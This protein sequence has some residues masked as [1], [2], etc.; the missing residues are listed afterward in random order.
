L[1]WIN[2]SSGG[3]ASARRVTK[4]RKRFFLKKEAKT[5][6]PLSRT[7]QLRRAGFSPPPQQNTPSRQARD[8]KAKVFWFFF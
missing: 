2:D 3:R 7:N 4:E 6:A 1:R 5:F 8:N